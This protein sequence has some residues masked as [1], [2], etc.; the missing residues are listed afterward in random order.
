MVFVKVVI[1]SCFMCI[2]LFA[3]SQSQTFP[4]MG[5]LPGNAFPLC[6][7]D[8][9]RQLILPYGNGGILEIPG[10]GNI[11][12]KN[13]YYYSFTCYASGRLSLL[14]SPLFKNEDYNWELF[15]VTGHDANEIYMNAALAV[16]GNW[17]GNYGRTGA[18]VTGNVSIVCP[19]SPGANDPTFNAPPNLIQGHQYLLLVS[20]FSAAQ[21]DYDLSFAGSTA[22][23]SNPASPH[24]QSAFVG[25]NSKMITIVMNKKMRCYSLTSDGS[26]FSINSGTVNITGATGITCS[27]QFDFDS[28]Q[29]TLSDSLVPGNYNLTVKTGNDGKILWDDCLNEIAEGEKISFTVLPYNR[30]SADF[31]YRIGYGCRSDTIFFNYDQVNNSNQSLWFID[32]AY[33]SSLFDPVVIRSNFVPMQVKH[34]LSGGFCS[35]SVTEIVNLD[36]TLKAGFQTPATICPG[37]PVTIQDTSV[38]NIFSWRWDFGDGSF[39]SQ[40]NPPAH[41]FPDIQTEKKYAVTL[42]VGNNLGCYDTSSNLLTKLQSCFVTVPSAFSPNGDGKNDYLYPLNAFSA[43][44]LEF[45]VFNRYGQLIF[46]TRDWTHKWDGTKNGT[47]QPEGTYIWTLRYTDGLS[48]K[49]LFL[50]GSTVLIR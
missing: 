10:C 2:S 33:I 29:L 47:S 49:K 13:P 31:T 4:V 45:M 44:D 50:R 38:G 40:Q 7:L 34:I 36:N 23:I 22:V 5:Q 9:F 14:I 3:S 16:T 6:A 48:R 18:T 19:S 43:T 37:D 46:E 21:S 20:C 28:L 8:T 42:I 25:C 24:V 27:D 1:F 17:S 15:D 26:D 41:M 32:S 12:I 39:S 30:L 35:D 11:I